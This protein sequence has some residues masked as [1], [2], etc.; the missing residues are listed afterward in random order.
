MHTDRR[1]NLELAVSKATSALGMPPAWEAG[2]SRI[3]GGIH[4]MSANL[5]GLRCGARL[6]TY[7]MDHYDAVG[8]RASA[9]GRAVDGDGSA[10]SYTANLGARQSVRPLRAR[11]GYR[12]RC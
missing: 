5:R 4:F 8:A 6:G 3:F 7:V 12:A 9:V 11:Y 2:I 1:I 10:R